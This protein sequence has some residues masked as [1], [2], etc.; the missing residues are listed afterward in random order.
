MNKNTSMVLIAAVAGIMVSATLA[1]TMTNAQRLLILRTRTTNQI[2]LQQEAM[3]ALAELV[4]LAV[5]L[6]AV[7]VKVAMVM[8]IALALMAVTVETPM[9]VRH[10][11][12]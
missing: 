3:E 9:A 6:L 10:K 7:L 1:V 4:E 11:T 8:T 5:Q 12:A 2:L